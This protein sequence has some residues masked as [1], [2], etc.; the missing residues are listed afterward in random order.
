[1]VPRE[2]VILVPGMF[3][4][5]DN[6]IQKARALRLFRDFGYHVL[7]LDLRGF[8]E[9]QRVWSTAGW[10]EAEDIEAAVKHFL[11][12]KHVTKLHIYSESLGAAA[13]LTAAG[14]AARQGRKLISGSLL[15]VSP[16]ADAKA[17]VAY[18]DLPR[19]TRDDF[20]MVHWFFVQLLKLGGSGARDFATYIREASQHHGVSYDQLLREASPIHD[21]TRIEVPTLILHSTDD[22]VVP[23]IHGD[24]FEATLRGFDNPMLWRLKWGNHC[25]YEML[26]PEWFWSVLREFFD[27]TCLLPPRPPT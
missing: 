23:A 15:A 4:S 22:V 13:A 12:H 14:R 9:S 8:G 6:A 17:E 2:G 7:V 3:S 18:L 19:L 26:D 1:V 5:K 20:F 27:F 10:Q 25:L 24:L 11:S 21:L 16:Y